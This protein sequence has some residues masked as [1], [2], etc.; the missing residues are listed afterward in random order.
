MDFIFRS[1]K[2]SKN[3][4]SEDDKINI[5]ENSQN[6]ALAK[7]N[8]QNHKRIVEKLKNKIDETGFATENLVE[9]VQN[10]TQSVIEQLSFINGVANEI[11]SYSSITEEVY[12]SISNSQSVSNETMEITKTGHAAVQNSIDSMK[13][14]TTSFDSVKSIIES[15]YEK[16]SQIDDMLNIIR[17]IASQTN[18][19][20]LNA[21][22]EAARAGEHGRGFSVVADEVGKLAKKSS[23]SVK[24]IAE[25]LGK[26]NSDIESTK[27]AIDESG[28][29]INEGNNTSYDTIKVFDK[30]AEAVKNSTNISAEIANALSDQTKGLDNL[31][32]LSSKMTE[33]SEQIISTLEAA[34]VNINF[35]RASINILQDSS[36]ILSENTKKLTDALKNYNNNSLCR[37]TTYIPMEIKNM[38]P[39]VLSIK[40]YDRFFFAI[41]SSLLT[42]SEK[43][44][45]LPAVAKSWFVD[46][47]NLTW[48]FSLRKGIKFHNGK[49]VT[50]DD[51]KASLERVLDPSLKSPSFWLLSVVEGSDEYR[52]G[53][54]R[55]VSGIKAIDRYTVSIKLT[56]PYA[57]FLLNLSHT[58]CSIMCKEEFE[59]GRFVGCGPFRIKE[60]DDEKYVLSAFED[61]YG[62]RPYTDEIIA[63]YNDPDYI[64]GI[65]NGRYDFVRLPVAADALKLNDVKNIKINGYSTLRATF[66]AF[67]FKRNSIFARDKKIREAINYAVDKQRIIKEAC[68]NYAVESKIIYPAAMMDNVRSEGFSY[69]KEKAKRLLRE[70]SYNNEKLVI[71]AEDAGNNNV[72]ERKVI[73][74]I[75]AENLKDIGIN[76]EFAY[77]PGAD[78]Y[79][80]VNKADLFCFGFSAYTG[81]PDNYIDALYTPNG[82][83]NYMG[84]VNNDIESMLKVC[85]ET[86]YPDKRRKLQKEIGD[87]I[88]KD[89]PI[90]FLYD[91]QEICV[92]KE[93]VNNARISYL[94]RLRFE[95]ILSE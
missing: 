21:A 71:L 66:A 39:A 68:G 94:C 50:S 6:N 88:T 87:S 59:Q 49:E 33:L 93:N 91:S 32:N 82:G 2:N 23:E 77:V 52:A 69:N 72:T 37:L 1:R 86:L 5:K 24:S 16:T 38:D 15:L 70:S 60:K 65:K 55:E 30:I 83:Y 13:K 80:S 92:T 95:D 11:Q 9:T 27:K 17:D 20:A 42:V 7:V 47:S 48:T 67:N 57:G 18:L 43:N 12:A 41:H 58:C 63:V 62:G 8:I 74:P 26:I 46:D 56:R 78:Y 44:E 36:S 40:D 90:V 45:V 34:S 25:T 31:L 54:S 19:L 76:V 14:I 61:F 85:N 84:Y 22:I 4:N 10:V 28:D 64:S 53:K 3:E 75:I 29:A 89:F 73:I 51:V 79:N 35:T 81:D